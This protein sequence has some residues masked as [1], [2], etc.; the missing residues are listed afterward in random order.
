MA[1]RKLTS[2]IKELRYYLVT[3]M[4]DGVTDPT[5]NFTPEQVVELTKQIQRV[6][7]FLGLL[8]PEPVQQEEEEVQELAVA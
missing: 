3:F 1:G 8:K 7:K 2:E 5:N 4:S 6:S